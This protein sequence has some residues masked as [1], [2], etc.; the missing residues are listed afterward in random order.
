MEIPPT[1]R[2]EMMDDAG[3]SVHALRENLRDIALM[4]RFLG[5]HA[6]VCRYLDQ[7]VPV[8][9]ERAGTAPDALSVLDVGTGGADV[10]AAIVA[11]G[12]RR[13]VPVRVVG[14]DRHPAIVRIAATRARRDRVRVV[15]ASAAALP[16]QN[17]SFDVGLCN[18]TLHHL[19]WDERVALLRRLHAVARVGFLVVDLL[20]SPGG[21]A[22]V[23]LLTRLF[24]NPLTRH[25]GPLSVRRAMTWSEYLQCARA[26][27]VAGLR[28]ARLPLFRVALSR[29]GQP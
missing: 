17:A 21:Y 18:L 22:G 4:N 28:L 6:I 26:A 3:C 27:D 1:T 29:T 19:T 9:R 14:I 25:D 16:F 13:R 15:Q 2:L 12:R 8:W 24:R 10:P 7:V 11:W 20:R 23:W 5:A